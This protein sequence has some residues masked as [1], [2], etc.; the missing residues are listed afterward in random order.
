LKITILYA[1]LLLLLF[2]CSS[3]QASKSEDSGKPSSA[4]AATANYFKVDPQTAG[5]LTGRVTLSSKPRLMKIV[6]MDEDQECSR[7][8]KVPLVDN[9][10]AVD[11]PTKGVANVFVYIKEGLQGKTFEPP[12][13]PVSVAQEGCW[14]NPRVVGIQVGQPFR[15]L[16]SDPLTHNIHPLAQVNREWNQSQEAGAE[17]LTRKFAKPEVMVKVKCNIHPWMR[18][19]LGVVDHPYFQVTNAE[20]S[21]ELK[22]LPPGE[23]LLEAWHEELGTKQLKVTIAP[24]GKPVQNIVF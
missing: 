24:S 23:Y 2:S 12:T 16:N 17:P 10:L 13:E 14:F 19:W 1:V 11:G 21:Y 3:P 9:A 20:G 22:N 4:S 18:G 7:L 6:N 15:V 8:H 5:A